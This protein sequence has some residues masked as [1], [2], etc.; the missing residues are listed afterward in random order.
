M[1]D[2]QNCDSYINIPSSQTRRSSF[3]FCNVKQLGICKVLSWNTYTLDKYVYSLQFTG[4][5]NI[6]FKFCMVIRW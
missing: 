1:D 4:T 6:F 3:F 2:V 5:S